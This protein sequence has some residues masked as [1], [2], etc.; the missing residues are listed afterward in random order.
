MGPIRRGRGPS[1]FV[2]RPFPVSITDEVHCAASR[3]HEKKAVVFRMIDKRRRQ[4]VEDGLTQHI[5]DVGGLQSM[6][7]NEH[8]TGSLADFRGGDAI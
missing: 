6:P 1:I 8:P 2:E 5:L 3:D 4:E 7:V